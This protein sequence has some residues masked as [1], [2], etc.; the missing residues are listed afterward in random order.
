MP[1]ELTAKIS[2]EVRK[3]FSDPQVRENFLEVQYFES[4]AGSPEDLSARIAVEE[5]KW[6]KL[7]QESH[8]TVER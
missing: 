3:I 6:R 7:I 4:I 5:P 8:I 2:N 1:P